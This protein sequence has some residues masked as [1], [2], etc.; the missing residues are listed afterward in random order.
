MLDRHLQRRLSFEQLSWLF[1]VSY[2]WRHLLSSSPAL[3]DSVS[4]ALIGAVLRLI[5]LLPGAMN[6]S[7]NGLRRQKAQM[8]VTLLL[9]WQTVRWL[10]RWKDS[11][12]VSVSLYGSGWM[13]HQWLDAVWT[14]TSL[15]IVFVL[16]HVILYYMTTLYYTILPAESQ[17]AFWQF[18][19]NTILY[20]TAALTP[21]SFVTVFV[22]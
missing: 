16:Y 4:W 13:S 9:K 22:L 11:V 8:E 14:P 2:H 17:L 10:W 7:V 1:N 20:Y 19:Y 12:G 5:K 6:R 18:L 3:G 15:F 21:A